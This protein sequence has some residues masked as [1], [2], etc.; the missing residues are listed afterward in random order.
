MVFR[1]QHIN[2]LVPNWRSACLY[3]PL[4]E[5]FQTNLVQ[6]RLVSRGRWRL[7]WPVCCQGWSCPGPTSPRPPAVTRPFLGLSGHNWAIGGPVQDQSRPSW[8]HMADLESRLEDPAGREKAAAYLEFEDFSHTGLGLE[9][10]ED[11]LQHPIE[12]RRILTGDLRW[13]LTQAHLLSVWFLSSHFVPEWIWPTISA[14]RCRSPSKPVQTM[15]FRPLTTPQ[16][17]RKGWV[18]HL[19]LL[20]FHPKNTTMNIL[21]KTSK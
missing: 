7:V 20:S 8:G 2:I 21:T 12:L 1:L 4:H 17:R 13:L 11:G 9:T 15:S 16:K 19:L 5:N 3:L 6:R 14:W 10:Y 18:E